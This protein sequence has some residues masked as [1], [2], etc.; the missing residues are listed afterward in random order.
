[1]SKVYTLGTWYTE[2]GNEAFPTGGTTYMATAID[3]RPLEVT[4]KYV[5]DTTCLVHI[6]KILRCF[7]P[8]TNE[9]VD[10]L[11]WMLAYDYPVAKN[12]TDMNKLVDLL[13]EYQGGEYDVI[14]ELDDIDLPSP[15]FETLLHTKITG[16]PS[17]H[18]AIQEWILL[19]IAEHI[20]EVV[21][22]D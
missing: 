5:T 2:D 3:E 21:V 18:E 10:A 4:Y 7:N 6:D 8:E 14:C 13:N 17:N 22:V 9:D 11:P 16:S 19:W 12:T 1:M 15:D 20:G